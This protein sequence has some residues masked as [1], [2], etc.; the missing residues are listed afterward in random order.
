MEVVSFGLLSHLCLLKL[1][2]LLSL[3]SLLVVLL[4]SFCAVVRLRFDGVGEVHSVVEC[5]KT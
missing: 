4:Y 2:S 5:S 3:L 1:L